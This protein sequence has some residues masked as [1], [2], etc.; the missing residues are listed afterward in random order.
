MRNGK[1]V[2]IARIVCPVALEC[3]KVIRIANFG[4]QFFE[5]GPV[6]LLPFMT[7]LLFEMISEV[8]RYSIVIEQRIVYIE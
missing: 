1:D 2:E 8:G 6:A 4:S 7:N 5:D 3:T